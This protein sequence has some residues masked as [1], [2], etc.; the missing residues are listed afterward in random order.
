MK[1]KRLF[2]LI[3][4]LLIHISCRKSNITAPVIDSAP[5]SLNNWKEVGQI[6]NARTSDIWFVSASKGFMT[7]SYLYQSLDSG[8]SW[9]VIPG[10]SQKDTLFNLFFVNPQYGFAQGQDH[11]AVTRDGGRSWT[12]K[13][14]RSFSGWTIQ[15]ISPSTGYYGDNHDFKNDNDNNIDNDNDNNIDNNNDYNIDKLNLITTTSKTTERNDL[16][17]IKKAE[18]QMEE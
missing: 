2:F 8:K 18:R 15:F 1:I 4:L 12:R 9:S 6:P 11:L 7:G 14:L 5:D 17:K 10:A 13:P 3:I 16:K